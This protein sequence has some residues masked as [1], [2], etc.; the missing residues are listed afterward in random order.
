M[1]TVKRIGIGSA[2]RVGLVSGAILAAILGLIAILLQGLLLSFFTSIMNLSASVGA[3]GSGSLSVTGINDPAGFFAM[4]SLA[5]ACIFYIANI[6]FS[7]VFGGIF[8]AAAAFA[9]NLAARWVGGL[10]IEMAG[11]FD[12]TKRTLDDDLYT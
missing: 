2:F 1:F 11:S 4:F 3:S 7:A 5:T 8:A 10:E 6:V 9:Y 12:K